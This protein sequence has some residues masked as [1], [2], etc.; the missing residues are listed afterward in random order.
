MKKWQMIPTYSKR[1]F[2]LPIIILAMII[3]SCSIE[4]KDVE[5][6]PEFLTTAS[7]YN[8]KGKNSV[9][10]DR[11]LNFG[12]YTTVAINRGGISRNSSQVLLRKTRISQAVDFSMINSKGMRANARAEGV[13]SEE[14]TTLLD[15]WLRN[16]WWYR[17]S[18]EYNY[19][20]AGSIEIENGS[21]Y[22]FII[23][24]AY[25]PFGNKGSYVT[26]TLLPVDKDKNQRYEI[27][28]FRKQKDGLT[29]LQNTQALMLRKGGDIIGVLQEAHPEK[30]WLSNAASE[31]E[32]F[33]AANVLGLL[34]LRHDLKD[35]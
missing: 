2:L 6:P 35:N 33:I 26:G 25:D 21:R 32:Q 28:S 22:E 30:I 19:Y 15:R 10:D 5:L 18:R 14:D 24:D 12:P 1:Q 20:F 31:E 27:A 4:I 23:P 7:A 17:D 29:F 3:S 34:L 16:E 8:V 13:V 9:F 11:Q